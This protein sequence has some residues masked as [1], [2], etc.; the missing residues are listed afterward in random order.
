MR[1]P[2]V[3][4]VRIWWI[5]LLLLLPAGCGIPLDAE[6]Q[7]IDRPPGQL[8]ASGNPAPV[9][10]GEA[11]L[12]LFLVR[13]GRLVRVSRRVPAPL[14]ARQQLDALLRGPTSEESADGLTS[15]LSTMTIT[16]M[17]LAD[18]RATVTLADPADQAVRTD[19]VLGFGQ[20]VCTLT[21]QTEVGTVSFASGGEPLGVPRADGALV[22]GP[23]TIADYSALLD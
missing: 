19:E 13:D 1:D 5:A 11:T 15:A 21:S 20:I 16:S 14:S 9:G 6:P 2:G 4:V 10:A 3:R 23:L 18:R 22:D 12:R 8:D 17:E 7:P